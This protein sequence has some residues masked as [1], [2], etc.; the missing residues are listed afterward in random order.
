MRLGSMPL[1]HARGGM[2]GGE[3]HLDVLNRRT[4]ARA[5]C[6]AE[7]ELEPFSVDEFW[8]RRPEKRRCEAVFAH[9]FGKPGDLECLLGRKVGGLRT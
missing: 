7:R 8:Y 6:D 1:E 3:T 9:R 2:Q 5:F 4:V